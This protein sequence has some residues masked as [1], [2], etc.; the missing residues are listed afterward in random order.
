MLR[1]SKGG[2]KSSTEKCS[3]VPLAR[4][5]LLLVIQAQLHAAHPSAKHPNTGNHEK[6]TTTFQFERLNLIHHE[7]TQHV[8]QFRQQHT[9]SEEKTPITAKTMRFKERGQDKL[10]KQDRTETP[11]REFEPPFEW[12]SRPHQPLHAQ[13]YRWSLK[14]HAD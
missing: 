9:A 10:T 8:L 2:K 3:A 4:R 13:P 14:K 7:R 11:C 12:E 5:V 1:S 6:K